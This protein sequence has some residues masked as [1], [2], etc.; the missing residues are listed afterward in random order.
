[1]LKKAALPTRPRPARQDAPFRRQ[2]RNEREPEAYVV[3]YVEGLSEARM[4][5]A[6]FFSI[7]VRRLEA[8]AAW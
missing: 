2:G 4:K 5:L 6:V 7:L 8:P 3:M 1:M